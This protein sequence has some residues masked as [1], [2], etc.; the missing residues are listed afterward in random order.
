MDKAKFEKYVRRALNCIFD[1]ITYA[2]SIAIAVAFTFF[3]ASNF[4]STEE[5]NKKISCHTITVTLKGHEYIIFE[6]DRGNTCCT[7]SE[8]CPCHKTNTLWNIK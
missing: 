1:I 3:V 4:P 2:M 8:S 7:H 6:T 5:C